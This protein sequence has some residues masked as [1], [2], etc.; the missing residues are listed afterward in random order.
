MNEDHK[1]SVGK[2]TQVDPRDFMHPDGPP[3]SDE[4]L[5]VAG[6]E[7]RDRLACGLHPFAP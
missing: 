6:E 5:A 4:E 2:A 1:L 3:F 7:I